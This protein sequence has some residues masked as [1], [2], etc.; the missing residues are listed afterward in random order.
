MIMKTSGIF[1][2]AGGPSQGI[3]NVCHP[4]FCMH[5]PGDA[6]GAFLSPVCSGDKRQARQLRAVALSEVAVAVTTHTVRTKYQ[7]NTGGRHIPFLVNYALLL[8]VCVWGGCM[9]R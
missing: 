8:R 9:W 6:C 2:P 7:A 4:S 1:S 5:G 3:L